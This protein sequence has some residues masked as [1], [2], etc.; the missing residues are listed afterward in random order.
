MEAT[1]RTIMLVLG[2]LLTVIFGLATI[3][4]AFIELVIFVDSILLASAIFAAIGILL[5]VLSIF[6][7]IRG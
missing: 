2:I 6:L 4:I 7:H 1:L 5:I 3:A